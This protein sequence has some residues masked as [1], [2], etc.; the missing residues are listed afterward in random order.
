MRRLVF[1]VALLLCL[2]TLGCEPSQVQSLS[3]PSEETYLGTVTT[4]EGN[5]PDVVWSEKAT[6]RERGEVRESLKRA[7]IVDKGTWYVY[8]QV[9]N[10]R[11][12]II[13]ARD[14]GK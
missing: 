1:V 9:F 4:G 7:A 3:W 12:A 13:F 11:R 10:G 5:H 2:A 8:R 6:E 14:K